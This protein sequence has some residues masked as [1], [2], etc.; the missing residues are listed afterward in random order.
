LNVTATGT[1]TAPFVGQG[2]GPNGEVVCVQDAPTTNAAGYHYLCLS[3]NIATNNA[4]I[5]I[6]AGGTATA[7]IL[8]FIINGT[9]VT[10]V[11]CSGSPTSS[12]HAINGIVTHC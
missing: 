10:P 9:T 11:T 6:G 7:G 1:G 3:A 8:T 4:T 12:F 2:T 5:S